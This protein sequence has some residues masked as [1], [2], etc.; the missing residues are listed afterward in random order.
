MKSNKLRLIHGYLMLFM[1]VMTF[2]LRAHSK[3]KKKM[4]M[5]MTKKKKKKRVID[6]KYLVNKI[7]KPQATQLGAL[8]IVYEWLKGNIHL[9]KSN[10][11]SRKVENFSILFTFSFDY[12]IQE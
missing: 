9:Y 5:M 7:R 10:S 3:E 11:S 2:A 1:L 12:T 8:V 6:A 4:M